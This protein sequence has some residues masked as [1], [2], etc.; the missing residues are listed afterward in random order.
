MRWFALAI[1]LCA[2]LTFAADCGPGLAAE[3][4][5]GNC[6]QPPATMGAI[7]VAQ[8]STPPG[9]V[10]IALLARIVGAVET[11]VSITA[12]HSNDV[13]PNARGNWTGHSIGPQSEILRTYLRFPLSAIPIGATIT[14]VTL[15]VNCVYVVGN[16]VFFIG[17]FDGNGRAD[18][19]TGSA[20]QAFERADLSQRLYVINTSLRSEGAKTIDLG[21]GA[22]ADLQAA[23]GVS[24]ISLALRVQNETG[25][26]H[27][28]AIDGYTLSTA[29]ILQ[30]TY[31]Q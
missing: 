11:R 9:Q 18:P 28:A 7:E 8:A 15:L 31:Q 10:S 13:T 16:D 23:L 27:F 24:K 2:R 6:R 26:D 29:P 17:P 22:V 4:L 21:A 19:T 12:D 30:V 3:D 25:N 5:A 1:V 20:A 14:A